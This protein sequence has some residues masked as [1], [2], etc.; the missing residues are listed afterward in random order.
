MAGHGAVFMQNAVDLRA[1]KEVVIDRLA[2]HG[3][4]LQIE[5]E[6]IVEVGECRRVPQQPVALARNQQR[7][8]HIGVVLTQLYCRSSIVEHATLMLT[9]SV[10][11][12]CNRWRKAVRDAVGVIAIELDR[13]IGARY[14]VAFVQQRFSAGCP[15]SE[16]VALYLDGDLELCGLQ[17]GHSR[18]LCEGERSSGA[19]LQCVEHPRAV[20]Y[21]HLTLPT[22]Y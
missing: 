1:V 19:G 16:I 11:S 14:A 9:Q 13:L 17:G 15:E 21:T 3:S 12:L 22:I 2:G 7:D 6:A 18:I 8:R 5:R 20:S 4:Q 10:E